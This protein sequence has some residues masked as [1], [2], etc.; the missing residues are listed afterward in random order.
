MSLPDFLTILLIAIGLSADC[1]AVAICA[2]I[3]LKTPSWA[4]VLRLAAAFGVFQTLMAALGWL[5]GRAVLDLI[6]AY[7]HWV[8]FGLLAFVGGRMLW[9]SFHPEKERCV[10]VTRGWQLVVVS[11]ATSL[12][13]LAVGLSFALLAINIVL[14]SSMIGA[15]AFVVTGVGF[16]AGRKAGELI[17]RRAEVAG[18]VILIGIGIRILLSHLSG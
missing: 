12:D 9:E 8:A 5:A 18:G 6:A 14:A 15:T 7:D 11:V 13:S 10:D 2:G 3:S 1:F 4:Q 17:G 16:L